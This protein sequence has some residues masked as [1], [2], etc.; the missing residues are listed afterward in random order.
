[1][2]ETAENLRR[3]YRISRTEQDEFALRS[4]QRA[5]TAAQAGRFADEIVPIT[6]KDAVEVS[7]DEHRAPTPTWRPWRGCVRWL[8]PTQ[9]RR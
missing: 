9:T 8:R 1:M 6:T 3:E 5:V 4:H 2:V 7:V